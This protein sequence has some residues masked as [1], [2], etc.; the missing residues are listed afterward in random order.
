MQLDGV[1]IQRRN[2][3]KS[4]VKFILAF[5]AIAMISQ[6]EAAYVQVGSQKIEYYRDVA[7]PDMNSAFKAWRES[8]YASSA[9]LLIAQNSV[10]GIWLKKAIIEIA[11]S[12]CG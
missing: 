6:A 11:S 2:R 3:G 7:V 5:L 8:Y 1:V 10:G 4:M 9:N 12:P